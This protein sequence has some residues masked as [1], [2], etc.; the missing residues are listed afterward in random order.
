M[1]H[2]LAEVAKN[3]KTAVWWANND[4]QC[5]ERKTFGCSR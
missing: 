3:T 4:I 2:V 1:T 5:R